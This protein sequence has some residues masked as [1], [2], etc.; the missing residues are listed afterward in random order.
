MAAVY[1]GLDVVLSASISPEPLGTVIIEAMTMARPILAPDHGG[2]VEMIENGRTGLLFKAGDA[3]DLA[4]KIQRLHDDRALGLQLGK[5][6]RAHALQVFA[7][8][9]HVRQVQ[10]VYDCLLASK[11]A[12]VG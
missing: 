4:A 6:A 8:R 3:D 11:P 10:R 12:N 2:A 1:N 7:I 5:A 9:E